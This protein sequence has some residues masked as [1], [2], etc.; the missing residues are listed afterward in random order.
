MK[1]F[2]LIFML[3]IVSSALLIAQAES[4]TGLNIKISEVM[5]KFSRSY[6]EVYPDPVSRL[7]AAVLEIEKNS[8]KAERS[9]ISELIRAYLE[10]SMDLSLEI[11]EIT[12]TAVLIDGSVA[13]DGADFKISLKLTKLEYGYV[14]VN[15]IGLS[16]KPIIYSYGA[17][18]FNKGKPILLISPPNTESAG[19]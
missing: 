11:G 5:E 9:K 14:S 8:N 1:K 13:E 18:T 19:V 16:V 7:G 2:V 4:D 10:E 6:L 15:R 12:G 3:V 17:N